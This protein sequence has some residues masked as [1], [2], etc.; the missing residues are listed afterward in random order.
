MLSDT[1][2]HSRLNEHL[3]WTNCALRPDFQTVSLI[4]FHLATECDESLD[5]WH[6]CKVSKKLMKV[7][8]DIKSWATEGPLFN[9][10]TMKTRFHPM[11]KLACPW[12]HC[13]HCDSARAVLYECHHWIPTMTKHQWEI[14]STPSGIHACA[15]RRPPPWTQSAPCQADKSFVVAHVW[16]FPGSASVTIEHPWQNKVPANS[17]S[18]SSCGLSFTSMFI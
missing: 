4:W 8:H 9:K 2:I 17:K 1:I 3:P 5:M 11:D 13:Q 12:T 7:A 15:F 14:H 18:C 6:D 10:C 16:L